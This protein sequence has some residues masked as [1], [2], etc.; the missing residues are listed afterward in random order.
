MQT[1]FCSF[2]W[3]PLDMFF[4]NARTRNYG[5]SRMLCKINY[6]SITGIYTFTQFLNF[7][8]AFFLKMFVTLKAHISEMETDTDKR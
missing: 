4:V 8:F 1:C 7:L 3:Q 5:N 2:P 6:N